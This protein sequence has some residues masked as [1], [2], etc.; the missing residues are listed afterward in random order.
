MK[1]FKV[2][3]HLSVTINED[4]VSYDFT[5]K[6]ESKDSFLADLTS[7]PFIYVPAQNEKIFTLVN[8]RHVAE[9]HV[10]EVN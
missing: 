7:K 10:Q 9:I 4:Q 6:A 8:M 1:E 3:V 5:H 2:T